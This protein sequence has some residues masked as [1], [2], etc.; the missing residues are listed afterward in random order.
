MTLR[1]A[2]GTSVDFCIAIRNFFT[3]LSAGYRDFAQE[4]HLPNNIRYGTGIAATP[5]E[6]VLARRP[7]TTAN[8]KSQDVIL[9]IP[10][11][12]RIQPE[13]VDMYMLR[14]QC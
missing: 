13:A 6:R 4:P 3:M 11:T 7:C 9:P 14:L 10:N 5:D 8:R 1:D 2:A 12:A